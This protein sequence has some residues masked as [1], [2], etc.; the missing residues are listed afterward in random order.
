MVRSIFEHGAVLWSPSSISVI[1]KFEAIQKRAIKWILS[2]Q[3]CVYSAEYYTQKL[4]DL[5]ILP[6]SQK[7][8]FNDMVMFY[9]IINNL[10]PV[11]L[12]SYV[13]SRSNTRS[14]SDGST[15]GIDS[16]LVSNPI[17][18]VFGLS[19]FPRCIATWNHLP[20][21]TKD[22]ENVDIFRKS[23]KDHLWNI[24]ANSFDNSWDISDLEPD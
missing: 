23:I 15:L 1:E 19:F 21:T 9:K 14:S 10:V 13:T 6:F 11:T 7:F 3:F 5:D 16:D 8:V 12:P 22:S 20:S 2:E 4:I 18:N 24:V 17:K